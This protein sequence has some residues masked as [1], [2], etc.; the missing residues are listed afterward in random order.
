MSNE[1]EFLVSDRVKDQDGDIGIIVKIE[2]S[3]ED[4]GIDL[5]EFL[6]ENRFIN[7]TATMVINQDR[8]VRCDDCVRACATAH[9]N[10][11]RFIRH[12]AQMGHYMVANAC[13][14]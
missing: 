2:E 13:M 5:L 11:P 4:I 3:K 10:N 9:G 7:G 8:C 14:H 1:K 12:G 6:V